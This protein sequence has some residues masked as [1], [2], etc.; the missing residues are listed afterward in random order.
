MDDETDANSL[1]TRIES[2]VD[3]AERL[4]AMAER[5][6]RFGR[7]DAA[8]RLADLVESAAGETR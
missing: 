5:S 8:E 3:H 4:D 1:S 6:Q 2:L 7:P